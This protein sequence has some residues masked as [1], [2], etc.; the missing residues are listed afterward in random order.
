MSWTDVLEDIAG[1]AS[2]VVKGLTA[3]AAPF[4]AWGKVQSQ[5]LANDKS[6]LTLEDLQHMQ[7]AKNNPDLNF[8][9][10]AADA[11][12]T[13]NRKTTAAGN[14]DI[15]G[16][17]NKLDLQSYL[18]DPNGT[19]QQ[20]LKETG[21]EPGSPEYRQWLAEA[22]G[23]FDP[24]AGV[25]AYD[26]YGV[27][28]LEDK[29]LNQEAALQFL[30]SYVQQKDP[31]AVVQRKPDGTVVVVSHGEEHEIDGSALVKIAAMISAKTPDDAIS[32]GIKDES[33]IQKGNIDLFKA[34]QTG[35]VTPAQALKV[36]DQQRVGLSQAYQGALR[37][38]STLQ[39]SQDFK[40][41]A[42]EERLAMTQD[43]RSRINDIKQKMDA[44][45]QVY[46]RIAA[47]SSIPRLGGS[48]AGAPP[49]VR[50]QGGS[51]LTTRP[52][53]GAAAARAAGVTTP[54]DASGALWGDSSAGPP[55][56]TPGPGFIR[57]NGTA[58]SG[59]ISDSGEGGSSLDD[60]LALLQ[61]FGVA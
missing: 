38:L 50:P 47:T 46:S 4:D 24:Q 40:M 28:K 34:L 61:Q 19:F 57:N 15:F 1:G 60:V 21:W 14:L 10:N 33:L 43:I 22:I 42:P 58:T 31:N 16:N 11:L 54:A 6:R 9:G 12:D 56:P 29:N 36:L 49:L 8:Y 20:G 23:Q 32:K 17:K 18:S 5:D 30:Q 35:Q 39:A 3:G 37:E 25:K 51:S 44:S 7:D 26:T 13:T 48:P 52:P 53:P 59:Q 27:D 55:Y 45:Q 2:G 41:A